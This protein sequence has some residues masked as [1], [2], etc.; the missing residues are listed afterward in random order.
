M[1]GV[2]NVPLEKVGSTIHKADSMTIVNTK[3]CD[4]I[5]LF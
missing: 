5:K 4:T 2:L 3:R 1:R